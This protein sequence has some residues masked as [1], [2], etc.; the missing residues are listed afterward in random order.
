MPQVQRRVRARILWIAL[1]AVLL[2]SI[3]PS[4]TSFAASTFGRTWIEVCT[5]TG[6]VMVAVDADEA[7]AGQGQHAGVHCPY[8]R[9]QQDLP[10]I[11]NAPGVLVLADGS[12]RGVPQSLSPTPPVAAPVWPAH[13]SRAPPQIS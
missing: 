9:L 12:V 10:A 5:S 2:G 13:H 4:V 11:A 3:A 7:P 8:C 1:L 6:T